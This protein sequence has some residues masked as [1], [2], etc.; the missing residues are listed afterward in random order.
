MDVLVI[1]GNRFMGRSLVL[2][3][4]FAR[5]RVTV[6]NRGTLPAPEGATWLR[7]D[8][9]TGELDRVLD[10]RTF[11]AVIDFACFTGED[12]R[13]AVRALASRTGHWHGHCRAMPIASSKPRWQRPLDSRWRVWSR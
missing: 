6:L 12:A 5:H 2:R 11:D 3:L 7:A 13:G 9:T 8:R 10:G 4:L 1:G